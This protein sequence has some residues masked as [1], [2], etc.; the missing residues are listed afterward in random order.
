MIK[1]L[2]SK[3]NLNEAYLQVYGNKGAGGIDDVQVTELKSILQTTGQRLNKQI[4]RGSYQVSPIK[5]VE[6]PKSNGK[7]RLLGIP[8]VV[9]R[10]YQ[11]ALHQVLQPLFE[12]D[13][14]TH[15]YGF[16]PE[17]NAHQA[18]QQS[19]ENINSGYQDILDIDLKSFFD[20]VEH[21]ILLELIYKKV[22]CKATMKLIRSFLRAPILINGKL[23]KR[24]K[25]VPQGSP[26]SP[27]LSNILLNELDK[28][29]EKRGHRYVRYADDFSIYVRSK[30]SA[31]RV[32]NSIYKFLRDKLQLPINRDKSGIRRPSSFEILGYSFVPTYK[33]GEKGKYQ[34]VVKKS[35]WDEFKLKLKQ[36]TK[37]T[38]PMSFDER[39]QRINWLIRG[40]INYFKLA[41]IQAKL[42]KLEEWLR[43]R[44][45]YCIW[46][47]WKKPERKRKNLIR[48]GIKHGMAYAWSRTRMGGWAVA[49]SP[50]LRTTITVKRLKMKGY[51]SLVE[52]YN[53]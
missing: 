30:K 21:Y 26:L 28:E 47:H 49:Q 27:L 24:R 5:G 19:L 22:K 25:G 29:L 7:T 2:T 18:L 36:L 12:P 20:E 51:V 31:K 44:L 41:S 48:L 14:R 40:W 39:I 15:S 38:T 46:H 9:D 10:F 37:K 34:F 3:K 11:Q 1:R 52:Y 16:R 8:T 43:N 17:R 42:K 4:E 45:R 35:K 50:I 32:G 6:I 23:Q 53:Q 33:K 13:F